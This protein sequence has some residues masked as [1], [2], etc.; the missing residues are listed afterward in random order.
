LCNTINIASTSEIHFKNFNNNNSFKVNIFSVLLSSVKTEANANSIPTTHTTQTL[1][2]LSLIYKH[3]CIATKEE[4]AY[5]KKRYFC[6]YCPPQDLKG[7]YSLTIRLQGYL[8]KHN[9][10]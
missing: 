9:I 6:K 8:R 5:I 1:R 7:H 2:Q 4:K 10:K 3:T